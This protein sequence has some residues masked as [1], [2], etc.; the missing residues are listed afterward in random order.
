MK[1]IWRVVLI[2]VL[3]LLVLGAAAIAVG[4]LTGGSLERMIELVFGGRETL[5]LMLRLLK[6]QL[7]AIF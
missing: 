7:A 1:N 4:A 3:V 2:L 6:E 5:E